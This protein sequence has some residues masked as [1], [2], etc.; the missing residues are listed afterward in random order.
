MNTMNIPGFTAEASLGSVGIVRTRRENKGRLATG[1]I[2]PAITIRGG[3]G[4]YHC[5][6][7]DFNCVDCT[8]DID[9]AICQECQAGGSLQCCQDPNFCLA[10]PRPTVDCT[11]PVTGRT[12]LECGQGG[13]IF[14]CLFPPCNV[15]PAETLP[16]SCF[17]LGGRVICNWGRPVTFSNFA[18]WS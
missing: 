12:C 5:S 17:R 8:D 13:E 14:C 15:V 3:G 4:G 16:P 9:N 1:T 7:D 11:D 10:N 18:S 6:P 2:S